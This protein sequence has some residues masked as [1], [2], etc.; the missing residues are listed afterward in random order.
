M[1][2][3]HDTTA[4]AGS[5]RPRG[6]PRGVIAL[7]VGV[8]A[9][10]GLALATRSQWDW[11][12]ADDDV[13]FEV[14]SAP[15]LT[16]AT[17]TQRRFVV[18]PESSLVSYTA[19][20]RLVGSS[21]EAV[22]STSAIAGDIVLDMDDPS[23]ST[24]G[25]MVVN[26]ETLTSDSSL[27]D[28]RLRHD[29]LESSHFRFAEFVPGSVSGWPDEIVDGVSYDLTV[30]GTLKVKETVAPVA[31]AGQATLT[32]DELSVSLSTTV[33][34]STF[35]IG[36]INI[37]GL[38]HTGD[39]IVLAIEVVAVDVTDQNQPLAPTE[40]AVGAVPVVFD[41]DGSSAFSTSIMPI[42]ATRCA[43][44]HTPGGPGSTTWEL[45][46]AGDVAEIAS[47]I[48]LITH[49]GYMPPWPAS[50]L[51]VALAD[52]WSLTEAELADIRAW[53]SSGATI[54]VEPDTEIVPEVGSIRQVDRDLVVTSIEPYQ[55]STARKDDYRCMIF[56]PQITETVWARGYG[57]EPDQVEIAHH[58]IVTKASAAARADADRRDAAEPGAGWTCYTGGDSLDGPTERAYGWAPGGQ[59]SFFGD[60]AGQLLEPGDFFV[61]QMHYHF[62]HEAPADSSRFIV[63]LHS[64]EAV[65]AAGGEMVRLQPQLYLGGAEIPCVEGG[66]T[67]LL[68]QCDRATELTRL[69]TDYGNISRFIPD[70][71]LGACG[72]T[73]AQYLDQTSGVASTTCDLPVGNPGKIV[74]MTGHMHEIGAS[75][76]L[77]LN[78]DTPNEVIL[79]D[80]PTWSFE[81]QLGY[82]PVD[83]I[84][85][86]TDD[87][88]RIECS[89]DR[90][91]RFDPDPKY[92]TWAEGT[93]DEM[94]YSSITTRPVG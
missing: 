57:F 81:W 31:L 8:F 79:L 85:I 70:F 65:A 60:D 71:L 88:I 19:T 77:T 35:D 33:L 17:E 55:G 94:C 11:L 38:V 42:V 9:V 61:V 59:G 32:G 75:I 93:T 24:I 25:T 78:P 87:V 36:P 45:A 89:W 41:P 64:P 27:R 22:G 3:E 14:P 1:S 54:D 4:D 53:V 66:P 68:P 10:G 86:T 67:S 26:V 72:Q 92:I 50:D 52:D 40:L 47:D 23:A 80:I 13:V 39:E 20:E 63:D 76:R 48:D 30:D 12:V 21:T 84:V 43:S 49:A 90:S 83:D 37:A 5:G 73:A 69:S 74:S 91:L 28:K 15:E 56:D 6:V 58:A 34:M 51:S 44:C 29:F 16:I 7:V 46:T 82:A 2:V 18:D 62:D